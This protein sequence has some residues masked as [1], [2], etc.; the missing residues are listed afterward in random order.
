MH[1][2]GAGLGAGERA[3]LFE[4]FNRLGQARSPTE[5]TGIGLTV[6]RG[7]VQP[8]GGTITVQSPPGVGSCFTVSLPAAPPDPSPGPAALA[9]A[10]YRCSLP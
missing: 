6:T 3:P 7:L 10:P 9:R 1:D 8:M 5:G 4:P 2:T